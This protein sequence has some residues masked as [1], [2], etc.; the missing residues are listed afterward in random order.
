MTEIY[1]ATG[2]QDRFSHFDPWG[3]LGPVD[4]SYYTAILRQATRFTKPNATP[5]LEATTEALAR[6]PTVALVP[7]SGKGEPAEIEII[8]QYL[9]R[10][11]S[12]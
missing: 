8:L 12:K 4:I 6:R 5:N 11:K 3:K 9:N 10:I 2:N 7:V 1:E